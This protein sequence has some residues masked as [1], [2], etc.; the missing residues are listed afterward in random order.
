MR[1]HR[2]DQPDDGIAGHQAV[3]IEDDHVVIAG[4]EPLDPVFDVAGFSR[5]VFRAVAVE[6][7]AG[8]KVAPKLQEAFLFGDP[9]RRDRWCRS[10]QT[11]RSCD[12]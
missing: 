3:G 1:L 11:S 10:A 4:A 2:R 5:G 6:N 9:D 12:P 8:A 7:I